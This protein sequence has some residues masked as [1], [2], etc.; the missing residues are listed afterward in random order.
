MVVGGWDELL[1]PSIGGGGKRGG[2][3]QQGKEWARNWA[4]EKAGKHLGKRERER[5]T[6][7]SNRGQ[8][9]FCR[10]GQLGRGKNDEDKE[11]PYPPKWMNFKQIKK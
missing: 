8:P 4:M 9:G 7:S 1:D 6:S 2:R 5:G 11:S 3:Q 10:G